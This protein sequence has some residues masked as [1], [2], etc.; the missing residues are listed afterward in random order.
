MKHTVK[1]VDIIHY[2]DDCLGNVIIEHSVG[3]D[4]SHYLDDYLGN[5]VFTQGIQGE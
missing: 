1:G 4:I 2:L 5:V 3:F